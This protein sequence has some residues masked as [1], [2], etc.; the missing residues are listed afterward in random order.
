LNAALTAASLSCF[1]L[2]PRLM[3]GYAALQ[4][5][6]YHAARGAAAEDAPA[7]LRGA[8][9]HA[10]HALERIAPLPWASEAAGLALDLGRRLEGRRHDQAA[11]ALY[12]EVRGALGRSRASAW[13]GLG[14]AGLAAEA[15]RLERA[16][17]ARTGGAAA[18]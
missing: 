10:S 18:P 9:R 13:R 14:L 17:R 7:H 11:L 12:T 15:E 3:D 2:G 16:A 1:L 4:W 8:A 5:V 6:R